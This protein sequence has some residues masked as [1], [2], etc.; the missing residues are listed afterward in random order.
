[1]YFQ[2]DSTPVET[3][4]QI[5][6]GSLVDYRVG[7]GD[8]E[9]G[10]VVFTDFDVPWTIVNAVD[11]HYVTNRT[12]TLRELLEAIPGTKLHSGTVRISNRPLLVSEAS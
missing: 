10:F 2:T 11:G 1:M 8:W 5:G 4:P 9:L 7:L 6:K 3:A 12:S